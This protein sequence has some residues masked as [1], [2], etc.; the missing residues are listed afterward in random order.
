M[1][2]IRN[3][4]ENDV[5]LLKQMYY[6]ECDE[7]E[8]KGIIEEWNTEE[9]KGKYFEMFAVVDDECL[10]GQVSIYEHSKNIVSLG[11]EIYPEYR[12]KGYAYISSVLVLDYAQKKGY[13]IVVSQVRTDNVASLAL[14]Q[15]LGFE[16]DHD[17]VNKKGNAVFFL[18]KSIV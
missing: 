13:K 17:Y 1:I 14:H 5:L 7:N 10:V 2:A 6:K 16:I 15:K 3:F 11:V 9:Y 4:N 12:R 18:I 8:I